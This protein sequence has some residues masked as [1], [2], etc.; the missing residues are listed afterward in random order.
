M[1]KVKICGLTNLEDALVAVQAG[2]DLLGFIFYEPSPRYVAPEVVKDIVSGVRRYVSSNSRHNL[3]KFV[4]VFVNASLE[5][6]THLLEFCQ[7]D[8]TQLHGDETPEF[9]NHFQGRAFKAFRPQTLAEA[10]SL[11]QKYLLASLLAP[12]NSKHS[13]ALL[14]CCLLDAYHSTLYGGTG[15]VT[16][17]TMAANIAQRYPMMLAGS[18]TP[19]NV[20]E[21][22]RIVR[23]WGVD[24]SSGVEAEK[25]RKNHE[26]M[27]EFVKIAKSV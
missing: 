9:V 4:G 6:V 26:K 7:L 1:T 3:P 12:S 20:A 24:V 8:L 10:E 27:R 22:I 2:A 13:P 11:I 14:P 23:P 19:T 5:I 16:D 18:L 15:H 25:G 17:W 21:A